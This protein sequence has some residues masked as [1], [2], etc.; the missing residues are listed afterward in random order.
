MRTFIVGGTLFTPLEELPDHALVIEDGTILAITSSTPEVA[1][2]DRIVDAQGKTVTPGFID[3]HVHGALGVDTMDATPESIHSMARYFAQHG[4]TSFLPTTISGPRDDVQQVVDLLANCPQTPDGAQHLGVHIEGPYLNPAYAGAQPPKH[5]RHPDP[6]EFQA[7]LDTDTVRLVTIAPELEGAL[8]FIDM[9]VPTGVEFALGHSGAS[10]EQVIEAA[11]H[12]LRQGSHTFNGM[13]GLHH[14]APGTVGGVLADERIYAQI[15]PDGIHVHPAVVK[16]LIRLKGIERTILV[17]D[18]IG[19]TGLADGEYQFAD[20]SIR[21]EKGISRTTNG[22]LA[23][24]TL[25]MDSAVRNMMQFADLS[26][27]QAVSMATYVPAEAMGWLD[28]RGVLKPGAQADIA[29]LDEALNV[30]MTIV[31]G[32]VVHQTP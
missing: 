13:L 26:L 22:A 7:W 30:V 23:G 2:G 18:A 1:P 28:R 9:A 31:A 11:D 10:Y 14:R 27:R 25:A 19:A 17:T 32:K 29:I 15:V 21:I 8:D 20:L 3:L 16:L 5:L 6:A 24:S 4:V 12:G